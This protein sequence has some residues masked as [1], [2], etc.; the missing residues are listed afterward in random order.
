MFLCRYGGDEFLMIAQTDAPDDVIKEVRECLREEVAK[1]V[2][3][4]YKIE[5]SMGFARWDGNPESFRERM[6]IA[7]KRMYEDKR[8]A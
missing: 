1:S 2:S 4:S 6:I 7:D 3:R 5:V 8:L